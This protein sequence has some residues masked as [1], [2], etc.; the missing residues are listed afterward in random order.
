MI[1]LVAS[2]PCQG[3]LPLEHGPFTLTELT[4]GSLTALAPFSGQDAALS[5]ALDAAF[6]LSLPDVGAATAGGSARVIW[7]G[8]GQYL[9]IGPAPVADLANVA[10][11]TDQSDA[12][13]VVR[14]SGEGADEVL[15]RLVPVDMRPAVFGEG[16][17]I[18]TYLGHMTVSIA[19]DDDAKGPG[20]RIM[21][22]RSMAGTLVHEIETAMA[23]VAARL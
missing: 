2:T 5:R 3:L 1:E 21:A 18:R 14:L 12:W 6:G 19:R 11:V 20:Y 9:L 7:F 22:F 15:A 23:A 16:A 13:A 8:R 4:P 10:A 17:A